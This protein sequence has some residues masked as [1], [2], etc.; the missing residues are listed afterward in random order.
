MNNAE[1]AVVTTS[2]LCKYRML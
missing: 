1:I 2:V